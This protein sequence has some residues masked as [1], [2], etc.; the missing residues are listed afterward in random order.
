MHLVCHLLRVFLAGL[1]VHFIQDTLWCMEKEGGFVPP[2]WTMCAESVS[3]LL[4]MIN[5]SGNFLIYCS[6]LAP[7]KKALSEVCSV[8]C[9]W[10]RPPP[11]STTSGAGAGSGGGTPESAPPCFL[12]KTCYQAQNSDP[13]QTHTSSNQT[14]TKTGTYSLN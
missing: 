14:T 3:S 6:M 13:P 10:R 12:F 1:A 7:F 8:V 5:F 2:L 9:F 4:I 11:T